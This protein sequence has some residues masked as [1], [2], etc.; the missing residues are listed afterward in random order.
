MIL[1]LFGAHLLEL[2]NINIHLLFLLSLSD[3]L[4]LTALAFPSHALG[5]LVKGKDYDYTGSIS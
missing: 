2:S 5:G 4:S 1:S 3:S